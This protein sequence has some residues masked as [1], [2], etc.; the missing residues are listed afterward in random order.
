MCDHVSELPILEAVIKSVISILLPHTRIHTYISS[1]RNRLTALKKD[2]AEFIKVSDVNSLYQAVVKQSA[3]LPI[4]LP[5][6]RLVSYSFQSRNSTT[7][8]TTTRHITT[9]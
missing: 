3:S 8:A 1:I 6:A 7:S 4:L 2:R 5:G 9:D